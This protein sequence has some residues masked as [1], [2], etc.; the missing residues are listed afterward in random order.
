MRGVTRSI[1]LPSEKGIAMFQ[2]L[3]CSSSSVTFYRLF[4]DDDDNNNR[5][6]LYSAILWCT[7]THCGL[8]HSPTIFKLK[9]IEVTYL[10]K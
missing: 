5:Y 10:R 7:H 8:Q 1:F 6:L 3:N 2:T 9:K 4:D